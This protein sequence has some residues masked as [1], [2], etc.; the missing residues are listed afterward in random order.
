[1]AVLTM[2][3]IVDQEDVQ[4]TFISKHIEIFQLSALILNM[5][6][7]IQ[8]LILGLEVRLRLKVSIILTLL[9]IIDSKLISVCFVIFVV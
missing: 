2:I 3:I 9:I 8:Y 7:L 5:P 6:L 4:N 1:M